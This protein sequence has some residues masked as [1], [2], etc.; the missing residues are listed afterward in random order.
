MRPETWKLTRWG[1]SGKLVKLSL[2]MFNICLCF[3]ILLGYVNNICIYI[4]TL[5]TYLLPS[6]VFEVSNEQ[7]IR[8]HLSFSTAAPVG[9]LAIPS[10]SR[11]PVHWL[12]MFTPSMLEYPVPWSYTYIAVKWLSYNM[13]I[14]YIIIYRYKYIYICTC[15]YT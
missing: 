7:L 11:A 14:F 3:C 4:Y 9:V 15:V 1:K 12:A 10:L 6:Q 13:C 5:Y 8:T 2:M